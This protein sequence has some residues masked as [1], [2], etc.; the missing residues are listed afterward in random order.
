[1]CDLPVPAAAALNKPCVT[2]TSPT[3][4]AATPHHA[5]LPS[6]PLP[7]SCGRIQVGIPASLDVVVVAAA[8]AC[9]S[10]VTGSDVNK[11]KFLSPRPRPK[12]QDQEQDQDRCLQDQDHDQNNK[13]KTT[14]SK[15]RHLVDL[16][17]K[18]VNATVDHHS[19]DV[20]STE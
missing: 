18:K 14:G 13:T 15:Q 19:S 5:K 4:P 11:T 1:M 10:R 16:T 6:P 17:F 20:P 8:A 12:S 9:Y 3:S 2:V 7:N